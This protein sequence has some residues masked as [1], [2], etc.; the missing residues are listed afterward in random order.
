[1]ALKRLVFVLTALSL[2][3]ACCA[4]MKPVGFKCGTKIRSSTN[5]AS[6]TV[7]QF[8]TKAEATAKGYTAYDLWNT[9]F[10]NALLVAYSTLYT[11]ISSLPR[12]FELVF[13][14][15]I[16]LGNSRYAEG[17]CEN[18]FSPLDFSTADVHIFIDGNGHTIKNF[19]YV[20]DADGDA[21]FFMNLGRNETASVVFA[22][23]DLHFDG[24]YVKAKG[25]SAKAAV[26]A[27][28]ATGE[29][30]SNVTVKNA[31]VISPYIAAGVVG[32]VDVV[33]RSDDFSLFSGVEAEVSLEGALVGGIAGKIEYVYSQQIDPGISIKNSRVTLSVSG[34]M[35]ANTSD[36]KN[37]V[38]G[39]VGEL[40]FSNEN[41]GILF[42][43][44]NNQVN[45][46]ADVTMPAGTAGLGGIAGSVALGSGEFYFSGN[47]VESAK[48]KMARQGLGQGVFVGGEVGY[49]GVPRENVSKGVAIDH[50]TVNASIEVNSNEIQHL[51][52][53]VG[54]MDF[55]AS[56]KNV[57][58][59]ANNVYAEIDSK[60]T[61]AI[62]VSMGGLVAGI[63]ETGSLAKRMTL[64]SNTNRLTLAMKTESKENVY[65]GGLFGRVEIENLSGFAG[66]LV[67][68]NEFVQAIEGKPLIEM[69]SSSAKLVYV[70]GLV[71]KY[72]SEPGSLVLRRSSV[73]GD[74][75]TKYESS[76]STYAGGIAGRILA[77]RGL[78]ETNVSEGNIDVL[79]G[80]Y[81]GYIVGE[82]AATKA[83][84][85]GLKALCNYHFG[86]NDAK[87]KIAVGTLFPAGN[88]VQVPANTWKTAGAN[89]QYTIQFNYRN[90]I[91]DASSSLA[92][93]G[94]LDTLSATP[95]MIN[96]ATQ[97]FYDGV[98]SESDMKSRLFTYALNE[99]SSVAWEN[100]ENGL[101]YIS[102][103][104]TVYRVMINVADIYDTKLKG[105]EDVKPY[106]VERSSGITST[107]YLVEFTGKDGRSSGLASLMRSLDL[108][109][110]N[111]VNQAPF[112]LNT[113]VTQDVTLK[114]TADRTFKVRYETQDR[115][116][117][118][119]YMWPKVEEISLYY[120]DEPVPAVFL[121]TNDRLLQYNLVSVKVEYEGGEWMPGVGG[122]FLP[123]SDVH[124][125]SEITQVML[126]HEHLDEFE[127]EIVLTYESGAGTSYYIP[128]IQIRGDTVL[129]SYGYNEA[130]DLIPVKPFDRSV[131]MASRIGIDVEPGY[132]LQ[133]WKIDF[134][135]WNGSI[136]TDLPQS[137]AECDGVSKICREYPMSSNSF[138]NVDDI[139][140]KLEP[141]DSL[142]RSLNLVPNQKVVQKWSFDLDGAEMLDMDSFIK[143]ASLYPPNELK[144][145][146]GLLATVSFLA[147]V[148]PDLE[149][150]PYNVTFDLN[151]GS[152]EVFIPERFAAT[153]VYKRGDPSTETFPKLYSKEG[154]FDGW[155]GKADSAMVIQ[156]RLDKALLESIKPTG[157]DLYLYAQWHPCTTP[158]EMTSLT[159]IAQDKNA[160]S[161]DFGEV[162]FWQS[163]EDA[164][165]KTVRIDHGMEGG[166]L[167]I[168]VA[169]ELMRFHVSA[170]PKEGY[171][172]A[173]L[174]LVREKY[175]SNSGILLESDSSQQTFFVND[176]TI[177][178]T[179]SSY[180]SYK[181]YATFGHYYNAAYQLKRER[182]GVFFGVDSDADSVMIVEGSWVDLPRTIYTSDSCVL[183]WS[184][185][186][187]A[188]NWEYRDYVDA[189][190]IYDRLEPTKALYA[191]WA[192]AQTCVDSLGYQLV[193]LKTEHGMVQFLE[194]SFN[195]DSTQYLHK[196]AED[197]TMLLPEKLMDGYWIVRAAPEP[198]YALDS[199]VVQTLEEQY[200]DSTGQYEEVEIRV[201]FMV[202]DTLHS[203]VRYVSMQA[204]FSESK[205]SADG[206]F[207]IVNANLRQSGDNGAAVRLDFETNPFN[208]SLGVSVNVALLDTNDVLLREY[209]P[210]HVDETPYYGSWEEYPLAPGT[211]KLRVTLVN[212][213]YTVAFDTLFTVASEIEVAANTWYMVSLGSV[214]MESV[215][216][217]GDPVF[218]W[219]DEFSIGG[220]FWQYNA[221][222]SGNKID[223]RERG[224]WYNSLEGR[225]LK[226]AVDTANFYGDIHWQID[227]AYSGWNLM[228]NPYG[229][230]VS[231]YNTEGLGSNNDPFCY[232][233]HHGN[234]KDKDGEPEWSEIAFWKYDPASGNYALA[235]T[236]GPY[237][238]VWVKTGCSKKWR[239]NAEPVFPELRQDD[240]EGLLKAAKKPVL[241]KAVAKDSW[242]LQ[243][244]L[245][246]GKGKVDA[247][248]VLGVGT[249]NVVV[250]EP[251]EAMGDHVNLSVVDGKRHLAKSVKAGVAAPE[252]KVELSASSN[253]VGYLSFEGV[254]ALREYGLKVF[255][256]VDG[257]T[258]EMREGEPLKVALTRTAKYATVRVAESAKVELAYRLDGVRAF[259]VGHGLQVS[260][261]A[262]DGL[263]GSAVQVDLIDLKGHVAAKASGK[264]QI[265]TNT[266]SLDAPKA[267]VYMLRV[268]AGS[269]VQTGRIMVK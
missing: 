22:V 29:S 248:N 122:A 118:D 71:G 209:D 197:S 101:P 175:D 148:T 52:G 77:E 131:R 190:S 65:A 105:N 114:S 31:T 53:V 82:Y 239:F 143:A 224:Y 61:S 245:G 19:C 17:V 173:K 64:N 176:T 256:T 81:L 133:R 98:I 145:A 251:P 160:E 3:A 96:G 189:D 9:Q 257:K 102:T 58:L 234:H 24:A 226:L 223:E 225:P 169:D 14:S 268:R 59:T 136:S 249:K 156:G 50:D 137:I 113:P 207:Q 153:G 11:S 106:L 32:L 16:D 86:D 264:A 85:E 146:S 241:A 15:D 141:Y 195:A 91:D 149:P 184:A 66:Q 99:N 186:R 27:N 187:N 28:M 168:P 139:V 5:V 63:S 217:D 191:V 92:A 142:R 72:E 179:P 260:F 97:S 185:E 51:G 218:Y 110:V 198:G 252:W 20:P 246:D 67:S 74:I 126:T 88:S 93:E 154:C 237:E 261:T 117:I 103:D 1:M 183:G 167:S 152:Y 211:Y 162:S 95:G 200:N 204:F 34:T 48:I 157:E 42:D 166:Y 140:K 203:H 43:V 255:V 231:I 151:A 123:K 13:D 23:S 147:D 233:D 37:Y 104:R 150:I 265:G 230:S 182:D 244:K 269:Q 79:D 4:A 240:N 236:I 47:K 220:D 115:V 12:G 172:L 221:L 80:E 18:A 7:G 45:L 107:L 206:P 258:T 2:A 36:A 254:D 194:Q 253:R 161:G 25:S 108:G 75:K 163:Y 235:D 40:D 78:V 73:S 232:N 208:V 214:D 165:S 134:W 247:W 243:A 26:V 129:T 250:A 132:T 44:E 201:V 49:F 6:C 174:F 21:S 68:Q 267:G 170:V 127:D 10:T 94:K 119:I 164:N 111:S 181:L 55:A 89:Q 54:Y 100:S 128:E 199:L 263:A 229:W 138:G 262:T 62:G 76:T 177:S 56:Q 159:P 222:K 202:G 121:K 242:T 205:G 57:S 266:L 39:L 171:S 130:G 84:A 116:P 8:E 38:G 219:W 212:D 30:F 188:K 33:A 215:V 213:Q 216:W 238:G 109:T 210:V 180:T 135:I 60:G 112:S 259:Q 158:I 144:K 125:F 193:K 35:P 46:D 83:D 227:S 178:F 41:Y 120:A 69:T 228:A 192:D 70:G 196:F 90:A 87:A 124:N 155:G